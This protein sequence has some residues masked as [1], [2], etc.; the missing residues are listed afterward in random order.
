[1]VKEVFNDLETAVSERNANITVQPLPTIEGERLQLRQLFQ[2]L[3]GNALKYYKPGTP[4]KIAIEASIVAGKDVAES[5]PGHELNKNFHQITVKDNGVG[6]DQTYSKRIFKI[7]QR[8][9][10]RSEYPGTGVGLAI[11]QKVVENHK[12]YVF[13][14]GEPDNGATFTILLPAV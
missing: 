1:M 10:G 14:Q 9:H 11:V 13:A 3:L 7:F 4:L 5:L 2:N 8:L 12:G 6:F